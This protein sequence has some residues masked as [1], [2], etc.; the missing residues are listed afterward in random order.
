MDKV[1]EAKV[2]TYIE[3]KEFRLGKDLDLEKLK[4]KTN[5]KFGLELVVQDIVNL[6]ELIDIRRNPIEDKKVGCCGSCSE[7]ECETESVAT[8]TEIPPHEKLILDLKERF[9]GMHVVNLNEL[10]ADAKKDIGQK[11][12][13][14]VKETSEIKQTVSEEVNEKIKDM[15]DNLGK[16]KIRIHKIDLSKLPD[17]LIKSLSEQAKE[18]LGKIKKEMEMKKEEVSEAGAEL[19][20]TVELN[21]KKNSDI[22]EEFISKSAK[23][24][25]EFLRTLKPEKVVSNETEN[26]SNGTSE[27]SQKIDELIKGSSEKDSEIL[28]KT[29]EIN[30]LNSLIKKLEK[31]LKTL[32]E[33]K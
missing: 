24:L 25:F 9:P 23:E 31:E 1:L 3:K 19:L 7:A 26:K 18:S 22:A 16:I 33:P 6:L 13:E 4:N 11:I 21:L 17:D 10:F 32:K 15:N 5:K 14:I 8:P 29:K 27:L 30:K 2:L 28:S 20:D 12:D